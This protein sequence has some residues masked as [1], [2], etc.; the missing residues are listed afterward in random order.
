MCWAGHITLMEEMGNG[1]KILV[2]K[3]EG[4][5]TLGRPRRRR[6]NVKMYLKVTGREGVEW[7]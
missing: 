4:K 3:P 1:Y 6:E 5:T 2:I 7:I